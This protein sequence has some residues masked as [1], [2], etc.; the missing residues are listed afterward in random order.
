ME[1]LSEGLFNG[2]NPFPNQLTEFFVQR[3]HQY[4]GNGGVLE[5]AMG[6]ISF[7]VSKISCFLSFEF[8]KFSRTF[9]ID[10]NFYFIE[11]L[12]EN[13]WLSHPVF[14]YWRFRIRKYDLEKQV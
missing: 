11:N 7:R 10:G 14:V 8:R 3:E 6:E 13:S 5:P 9:E 4:G 1:Q 2:Q 12:I